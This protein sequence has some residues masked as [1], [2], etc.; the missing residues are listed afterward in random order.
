VIKEVYPNSSVKFFIPIAKPR[1]RKQKK[2]ENIEE[3]ISAGA[4]ILTAE[5]KTWNK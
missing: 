3:D 5:Q 1:G 4:T 2:V